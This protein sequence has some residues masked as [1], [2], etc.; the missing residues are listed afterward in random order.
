MQDR[1]DRVIDGAHPGDHVAGSGG[2]HLSGDVHLST[3]L[4][5]RKVGPLDVGIDLFKGQLFLVSHDVVSFTENGCEEPT[6]SP[7]IAIQGTRLGLL[8]YLWLDGQRWGIPLLYSFS[9]ACRYLRK[10]QMS[11]SEVT[12]YVCELCLSL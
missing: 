2:D 10:W 9:I 1:P 4:E 5:I 11:A 7:W 3:R 6:D 12:F 8:S